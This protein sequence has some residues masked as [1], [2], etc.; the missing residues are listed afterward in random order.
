MRPREILSENL[1]ALKDSGR[2]PSLDTIKKIA[3]A[4][5]GKLSNGKVGRIAAGSHTT[6]IEALADLAEVFGLQPWQLLVQGLNP[7][8]LPVLVDAQFLTGLR[9]MVSAAQPTQQPR[10]GI[11][12]S[13]DGVVEIPMTK[14]LPGRAKARKR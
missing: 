3:Q 12:P 9:D 14:A 8:A 4:S 5:G 10:K 1:L 13:R 11:K 7:A 2:Y 6:D